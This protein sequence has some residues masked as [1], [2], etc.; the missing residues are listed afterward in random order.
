MKK[1]KI[2]QEE[3][4]QTSAEIIL[5][6]G[7]ILIIVILAGNYIFKIFESMNNSLESLIEKGRE[8]ILCKI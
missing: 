8:S 6:M 1:N 3:N 7:V 4:G 5:L 2:F